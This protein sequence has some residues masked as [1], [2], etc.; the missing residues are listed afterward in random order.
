MLRDISD[1]DDDDNFNKL[2]PIQENFKLSLRKEEKENKLCLNKRIEIFLYTQSTY[3]AL[4]L[5]FLRNL[6]KREKIYSFR[7]PSFSRYI[8][9]HY[10]KKNLYVCAVISSWGRYRRDGEMMEISS[11]FIVLFFMKKFHENVHKNAFKNLIISA[12]FTV[13]NILKIPKIFLPSLQPFAIK[14]E[15]KNWRNKIEKKKKYLIF[16]LN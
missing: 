13:K 15:E 3:F 2:F 11:C 14:Y 8:V 10:E 7:L 16:Y 12:I 5:R 6:T 1:S 9:K 4:K